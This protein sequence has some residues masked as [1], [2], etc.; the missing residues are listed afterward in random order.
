MPPHF[1]KSHKP[2][3]THI[4]YFNALCRKK[5]ASIQYLPAFFMVLLSIFN[6]T[7]MS[8]AF[9]ATH[10]GKN[11]CIMSNFDS[12]SLCNFL[13]SIRRFSLQARSEALIPRPCL[14]LL[15]SR[16]LRF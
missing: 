3:R 11:L 14:H 12:L 9:F 5:Q 4:V 7:T 15:L 8:N 2:E 6:K 1:V 16:F 10:D 13:L